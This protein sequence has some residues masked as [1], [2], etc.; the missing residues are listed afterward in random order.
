MDAAARPLGGR[1]G[2][3]GCGVVEVFGAEVVVFEGVGVGWV[4]GGGGWEW[5]GEA[6]GVEGGD[7][8]SGFGGGVV[9]RGKSRGR[10]L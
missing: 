4:D 7:C 6:V 2:G 9:V 3:R 10:E 8:V 1:V 5:G